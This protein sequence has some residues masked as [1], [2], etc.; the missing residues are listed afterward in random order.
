MGDMEDHAKGSGENKVNEEQYTFGFS[1]VDPDTQ[2]QM[3]NI[4]PSTLPHL[5]GKV[6]EDL[7]SFLFEFDILCRSYDY[8]L[9]AKK[10]KLFLATLKE[11]LYLLGIK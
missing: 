1:V 11:T 8:S 6:H 5:S 3:K 7:D 10:L 4:S 9:D 2:V